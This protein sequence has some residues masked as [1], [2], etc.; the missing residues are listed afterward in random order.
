MLSFI[1]VSLFIIVT[2]LAIGS[3]FKQLLGSI[4]TFAHCPQTDAVEIFFAGLCI[5]GTLLN[6]WSLL[7]ATNSYAALVSIGLAMVYIALNTDYFIQQSLYPFHQTL[8]QHNWRGLAALLLLVVLIC[9]VIPPNNYDSGFYH[10]QAIKWIEQYAAVPGLGNLHGRFAFNPSTFVL[11][12]ATNFRLIF[13]TAIYALNGVFLIVFLLWLLAQ[14]RQSSTTI[15]AF[16]YTFLIFCC[17]N[18]YAMQ[19][20]S[21]TPDISTSILICFVLLRTWQRST[22][23]NNATADKPDQTH[24]GQF[25]PLIIIAFYT[26]TI[27]LT[28]LPLLLLLPYIAWLCRK[29]ISYKAVIGVFMLG[30]AIFTPWLLRNIVLSGYLVYPLPIDLFAL[31]WKIPLENVIDERNWVYSWARVPAQ[32]WRE[33]LNM[34][35]S[36]W[37]PIWFGNLKIHHQLIVIWLAVLLPLNLLFLGICQL[38]RLGKMK[39]PN[40][41]PKLDTTWY[42]VWLIAYVGCLYWF[43]MAPS[44][45]FGSAFIWLSFM[46]FL[47]FQ[48]FNNTARLLKTCQYGITLFIAV[49]CLYYYQNA[50][51][52]L[53]GYYEWTTGKARSTAHSPAEYILLPLP[54]EAKSWK[55]DL[56]YKTIHIDHITILQPIGENRCFDLGLPCSPIINP[57]LQLRGASLANGFRVEAAHPMQLSDF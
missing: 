42:G 25:L 51:K 36:E 3:L 38:Y 9:A 16:F 1:W 7:G 17:L 48:R 12:A 14:L 55:D 28:A 29:S 30:M 10:I 8:W 5:W 19:T 32:H 24:W 46:P 23:I 52:Q 41:I 49:L 18:D 53:L 56:F 31:D 26:V 35:T 11:S 34:S 43:I 13:G 44:F 20:S 2:A 27:K 15:V 54:L 6:A 21:P 39:M 50:G 33:V 40:F 22:N 37:L 4:K 57:T 47:L 45:R